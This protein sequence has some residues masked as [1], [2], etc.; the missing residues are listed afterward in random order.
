[1]VMVGGSADSK[2]LVAFVVTEPPMSD[3]SG[4]RDRLVA[5]LPEHM[6]AATIICIDRLPLTRSGK[7]DREPLMRAPIASNGERDDREALASPLEQMLTTYWSE[8]LG[9]EQVG[10]NDDFFLLGG[11]S[12]MATRIIARVYSRLPLRVTVREFARTIVEQI[13]ERFRTAQ[14]EV[15]WP[16]SKNR[17]CDMLNDAEAG[18]TI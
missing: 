9:P 14:S 5:R 11:H 15:S 6:I 10:V 16:S 4:I 12:L 3:T 8:L 1:M 17:F 13:A 2:R 7:L 18:T